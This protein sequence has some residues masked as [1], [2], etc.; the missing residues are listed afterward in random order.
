[1]SALMPATRVAVVELDLD[2]YC[3]AAAMR[4]LLQR[5]LPGFADGRLRID[6]LQVRKARRNAS[7]RRN[8]CPI[9]LCYELQV[10][11]HAGGRAGTQMLYAKVF[12]AGLADAFYRRQD[13]SRLTPPAFGQA[14]VHVAE[15]SM[16]VWALPNDPGLPQLARLLDSA[17]ADGVPPW[18]EL[19]A[20]LGLARADIDTVHAELLRYEP[21][22][23]ATLRYTLTRVDG[24][25]ACV[26]YA[27]TFCDEQ[28]QAIHRRFD[29]FWQLALADASAPLVAQPLAYCAATQTL[30]Q[31]QASGMPLLQMLDLP[32]GT[33]LIGRVAQALALLHDAP[34][35]PAA[36]VTARSAAHWL[37]EARRR[38]QKI[39]RTDAAL[40]SRAARVV[41][42]IAAHT[43][44][45][46]GRPLSLI[47][48]DFHPEQIWVRQGRVVL[49]DFDEFTFGDPMEDLAAFVLK[50]EQAGVAPE[51]GGALVDAY[52]ARAPQRFDQRSLN[53]HLAVQSLVQASRAF[54]FQQPGWAAELECRLARSE[55]RAA[56]LNQDSTA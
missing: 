20:L 13:P 1:M 54:I 23:R 44:R 9:T 45:Q 46:A 5:H 15:L 18:S 25:P 30:W 51:L 56:A 55:A 38:Q 22:S 31:A 4:V 6:A 40:A 3:D 42:A 21:Q 14:L 43:A 34:L 26:L 35:A 48:G 19:G 50:L 33:V 8:P 47:H 28:A 32:Q 36:G 29:Y 24:G 11:E 41:E 53:W 52:A 10:S 2:T 12:R 7:L 39:S 17:Q 16:V 49:F 37:A 27:K